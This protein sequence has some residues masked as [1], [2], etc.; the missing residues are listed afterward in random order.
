M[1]F[2]KTIFVLLVG[3][4]LFFTFTNSAVSFAAASY[5]FGFGEGEYIETENGTDGF[6]LMF[7]EQY[8]TD[9]VHDVSEFTDC[10]WG[11]TTTFAIYSNETGRKLWCPTKEAKTIALTVFEGD[12]MWWSINKTGRMM[13]AKGLANVLRWTAP[14]DGKYKVT[15]IVHGGLSQAYF[16][17]QIEYGAFPTT[18]DMDGV[19]CSIYKEN[20][21]LF[22]KNSIILTDGEVDAELNLFSNNDL[23]APEF[24]VELESGESMYFITDQNRL[25]DYDNS[26]WQI[27]IVKTGELPPPS[28]SA[29]SSAPTSSAGTSSA[30]S[31][32]AGSSDVSSADSGSDIGS[33]E[34]SESE[35]VSET[36]E[37][38]SENVSD[39]SLESDPGADESASVS[40]QTSDEKTGKF[41]VILVVIAAAVVIVALGILAGVKNAKKNR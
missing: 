38:S 22:S 7:A 34:M 21:K 15:S 11:N 23:G 31:S 35:A 28:S 33:S 29:S 26:E 18:L 32:A 36:S 10:I 12:A 39:T 27:T 16:D 13:P 37:A 3:V 5:T 1:S 6:W 41:P 14:A 24:N 17:H 20:E 25:D 19:T 30:A 4:L 8:N 2:K 9:G 40:S